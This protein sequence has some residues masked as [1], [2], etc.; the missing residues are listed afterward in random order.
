MRLHMAWIVVCV[1]TAFAVASAAAEASPNLD[2]VRRIIDAVNSKDADK[3]ASVFAE[4][5]VV[6]MYAGAVRVRGRAQLRENRAQHFRRFPNTR[7]EIQ[8][9]VEIGTTVVMHDRVW[10][11]ATDQQPADIVEIF[12]FKDDL[13]IKVE[14]IQPEGLLSRG[15]SGN[16]SVGSETT[17]PASSLPSRT[18]PR[19]ALP[20]ASQH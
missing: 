11:H 17:P 8:H 7:S 6:Q 2:S 13:I 10:L 19:P 1:A 3:Y 12:T 20:Q 5:A 9:L 18:P 16:Q 4:D 15:S 14:V